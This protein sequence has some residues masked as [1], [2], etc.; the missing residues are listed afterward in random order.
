MIKL[1]PK[2]PIRPHSVRKALERPRRLPN[3]TVAKLALAAA[4]KAKARKLEMVALLNIPP[5][6][7]QSTTLR[8]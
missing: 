2:L 6:V 8:E 4:G 7:R 3:T 5:Q 1:H